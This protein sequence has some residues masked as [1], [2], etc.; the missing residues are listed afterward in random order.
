VRRVVL[1]CAVLLGVG[2]QSALATTTAPVPPATAYVVAS[3]PSEVVPINSA[4]KAV[5]TPILDD[6]ADF[7]IA[8]APD[9]K[10]LYVSNYNSN[11]F[12][13]ESPGTVTPIDIATGTAEAAIPTGGDEPD[14]VAITPNGKTVYVGNFQSATVTPINAATNTAGTPFSAGDANAAPTDI[15]MA[16]NGKTLY[17]INA[18]G[19]VEPVSTAT[20]TPGASITIGTN[21]TAGAITPNGQTLYVADSVA[22][23][24]T[25]INTATGMLG[26]P[27]PVAQQ[28]DGIAITPNG[29]TAY[30]AAIDQPPASIT[31]PFVRG[32]QPHYQD[33]GGLPAGAVTPINLATNTAENGIWV[34]DQPDGI[35]ITPN[36]STVFVASFGDGLVTPINVGTNLAGNSFW[37]GNDLAGMAMSPR[38]VTPPAPKVSA[39]RIY[40]HAV[41]VA[42][43]IKHGKCAK[44]ASSAH[45]AKSCQRPFKTRI[46]YS[47]NVPTTVTITVQ[48]LNSG[49][50]VGGKCVAP[51]KQSLSD[52]HCTRR[53]AVSGTITQTLPNKGHHK[54]IFNGQ[55]GGSTLGAGSYL[56]TVTPTAGTPQSA[57]LQIAG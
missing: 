3:L 22:N 42:G 9:G 27:I 5:G 39:L 24:V 54:Y 14:T 17:V 45:N 32:R 38:V 37:V 2:A 52:K 51:T 25:P 8:V 16:P 26:T 49:R 15:V 7:G 4:T 40:P 50:L 21:A 35:A 11:F 57:T 43:Q 41:S 33:P 46:G 31:I 6:G 13:G 1:I 47:L 36:G 28:P 12:S 55:I 53:I 23:T 34:P 44:P 10:T 48:R 29:K 19:T 18:D 56:I 30:V 20:N